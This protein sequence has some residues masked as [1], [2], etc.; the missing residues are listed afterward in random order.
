LAS[1]NG[2]DLGI[3]EGWTTTAAPKELQVSGYPGVNGTEVVDM[4]ARGGTTTLRGVLAGFDAF[5]LAS[6]KATFMA[7]Q[8]NGGSYTLVDPEFVSWFPVILRMF[9]PAEPRYNMG[10]AGVAQRYEMEFFHP[11]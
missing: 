2:Y 9:R 11:R 1:F 3:V 6:I 7:L 5:D 4:G 8:I 10:I